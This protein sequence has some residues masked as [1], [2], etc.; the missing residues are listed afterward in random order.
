MGTAEI[1]AVLVDRKVTAPSLSRELRASLPA[2]LPGAQALTA[3][4]RVLTIASEQAR[5]LARLLKAR[6]SIWIEA[7]E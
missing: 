7:S 1:I 5:E 2:N 6:R 3:N 4:G